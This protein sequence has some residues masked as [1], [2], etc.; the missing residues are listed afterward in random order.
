MHFLEP[1]I[2]NDY[3]QSVF[4]DKDAENVWANKMSKNTFV[5]GIKMF[6]SDVTNLKQFDSKADSHSTIALVKQIG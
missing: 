2:I 6:H 3:A 4:S 1:K 5:I